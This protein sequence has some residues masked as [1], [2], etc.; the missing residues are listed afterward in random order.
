[1]KRLAFL[2]LGV[3]LATPLDAGIS[4]RASQKKPG[5]D[6][7]SDFKKTPDRVWIGADYWANPMEDWSIKNGRLECRGGANRNVALL[8]RTLTGKGAFQMSVRLGR[9]ARPRAAGSAG[10]RIGIRDELPDYRAAALR[11][12]GLNVGV[13]AKTGALF[14]G[15]STGGKLPNAGSLKDVT[16]TLSGKPTGGRIALTLTATDAKGKKLAEAKTTVPA[17]RVKGLVALA[18]NHNTGRAAFWF[19]KWT[20]SGADVASHKDRAWGPILWTMHTLHHTHSKD[21]VVLKLTAQLVPMGDKGPKTATLNI[22]GRNAVSKAKVDPLACN[23]TFRIT[24]WDPK[25]NAKFTVRYGD[26]NYTGTIRAE[27]SGKPLVVAGF[28]GNTDYVFP[29]SRVA[30]NVRV[31][32]PDVLFFSGDQ[33]YE[34]VGGYGIV[35]APTDTADRALIRRAT[36]NYLRKWY[37]LG[38]AF[39][40]LMRDRPT[41]CLPDDHD[42]YQGNVW[43]EGGLNPHGIRNHAR[44]GFAEHP[45]F[46]NTVI[47]TQCSHHP[48][49][50]DPR[51]M[52]QGINVFFGP[53]LYGRVSFAIIE[54]RYFKSGPEDKVNTWKGRPDHMKDPKYDVSKLDKPGLQLLGKRQEKFLEQWAGD[55]RGA[56][57]KCVLSQTIFCNLANYHGPRREF[58]YADLD[59]NGWPQTPRKNALRIMRKGYAFHYAGDQHLPSITRNGIDTWGD[60]G[61]AFCVPSIAAGYPRSWLPDKEGRPVRNRPNPNLANTGEYRDGFGNYMTVYGIGNPADKNRR[62]RVNRAH[63][64]SSGHAIVRFNPKKLT[65]TMECYRVQINPKNPRPKDQFPG[66]PKTIRLRDNRGQKITG[67]LPEV[68]APAGVKRPVLRVSNAK[69][70]EL[71]YAIRLN[72]T[73]VK[74]WVFAKG[75]Y[76]VEVGDPVNDKWTIVREASPTKAKANR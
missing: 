42:V 4:I 16:L 37:L 63:D 28:T 41:V 54:D 43:G 35:R 70:G 65:I 14:I 9:L 1:M 69:T 17:D 57:F 27:P 44:G 71:N 15:Q 46:V 67:Y 7:R 64:K 33:I 60:A 11:G 19:S 20:L 24:N 29:N 26:A 53:M 39:G 22:V 75:T 50:P 49:L 38:W 55:W 61:F 31:Q 2:V 36:L 10:F 21:G 73:R 58:I 32:N 8:T 66:W 5:G 25:K 18:N 23:A 59:S 3:L 48:D 76:K 6:F 51:P 45:T 12:R 34:S 68:T 40:D 62:G 72:Q 56:D 30:N 74:P 52:K 47:R 13:N